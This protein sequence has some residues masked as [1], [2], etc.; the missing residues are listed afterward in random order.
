[1]SAWKGEARTKL[2]RAIYSD[3]IRIVL[4]DTPAEH[5]V[6]WRDVDISRCVRSLTVHASVDDI[7]T[8]TIET[9]VGELHVTNAGLLV[10]GPPP[11]PWWK[12]AWAAL[13]RTWQ[14]MKP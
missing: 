3:G 2:H 10:E 1:M 14:G 13:G 6:Y 4:G 11:P 12:R 5:R 7:T 8:A 9:Y